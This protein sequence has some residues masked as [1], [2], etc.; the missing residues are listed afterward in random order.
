MLRIPLLAFF[1]S[2]VTAISA[3]QR[4][5]KQS[6]FNDLEVT[7]SITKSYRDST[8]NF[9]L[10]VI[11][12]SYTPNF[13]RRYYWFHQGEIKSTVGNY[14]G[15]LLHGPYE[16]YDRDA[17]LLEKGNFQYGSKDGAWITW[18]TSGNV[19]HRYVWKDG[20]RMGKFEE[21]Y[22]NG[23]IYRTGNYQDD[24]LHGRL[25]YYNSDGSLSQEIKYRH[26]T[27][28]KKKEKKVK[29]EPGTETKP[30]R[31]FF[32]KRKKKEEIIPASQ[33]SESIT[34]PVAPGE[35]QNRKRRRRQEKVQ[36]ASQQT[37]PSNQTIPEP[38]K[39]RERKKK[40]DILIPPDQQGVPALQP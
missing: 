13:T 19:R 17:T 37:L 15:K 14:S 26:G 9:Y 6:M 8:C 23:A 28:V 12:D 29:P 25:Y 21:Y 16:K 32:W 38:K 5:L 31:L 40:K 2:F 3:Q 35:K 33:P 30:N 4:V 11:D 18:Y 39:K 22:G 7:N 27:L 24:K 1:I 34:T 10:K 36:D 20:K